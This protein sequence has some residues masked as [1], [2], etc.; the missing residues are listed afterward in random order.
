MMR[1]LLSTM[2]QPLLRFG[3]HGEQ[4]EA[5]DARF[6]VVCA[7]PKPSRELVVVTDLEKLESVFGFDLDQPPQPVDYSTPRGR[8]NLSALE[9]AVTVHMGAKS[10]RSLIVLGVSANDPMF[11]GSYPQFLRLASAALGTALRSSPRFAHCYDEW[12]EAHTQGLEFGD[13]VSSKAWQQPNF[14]GND[15]KY[16]KLEIGS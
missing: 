4:V 6:F 16:S 11:N 5:C 1:Y 2:P 15:V 14:G 9:L 10:G 3:H 13:T 12:R 7:V 8:I